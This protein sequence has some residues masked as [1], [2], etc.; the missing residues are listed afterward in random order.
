MW[1]SSEGSRGWCRSRTTGRDV[2]DDDGGGAQLAVLAARRAGGRGAVS[3]FSLP[4]TSCRLC[5][6]NI[7]RDIGRR[8]RKRH[9]WLLDVCRTNHAFTRLHIHNKIIFEA[10]EAPPRPPW[11]FLTTKLRRSDRLTKLTS[12][13]GGS[14]SIP[15]GLLSDCVGATLI[16][17][18]RPLP[19]V[20]LAHRLRIVHTRPL[21]NRPLAV[22]VRG[23]INQAARRAIVC[24]HKPFDSHCY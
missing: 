14:R 12:G 10:A 9:G 7:F 11:M 23:V 5:N 4:E 3:S 6:R 16:R 2:G 8:R 24:A 20:S 13:E 22:A 1:R 17:A 21:L 15:P 18:S 19:V